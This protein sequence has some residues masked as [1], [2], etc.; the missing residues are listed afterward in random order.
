[1]SSF[2]TN[3]P[4]VKPPV[5]SD[6]MTP[7]VQ[8]A[9]AFLSNAR[10]LAKQKG[11][12][13]DSAE[14]MRLAGKVPALIQQCLAR[15]APDEQPVFYGCAMDSIELYTKRHGV[16]P[17]PDIVGN[18]LV[19]GLNTAEMFGQLFESKGDKS[20]GVALDS[21]HYASSTTHAEHGLT[22][23]VIITA[24]MSAAI[25]DAMPWITY[26]P[27]NRHTIETK[28]PQMRIGSNFGAYREGEELSAGN[29]GKPYMLSSRS[30]KASSVG[31]IAY[32]LIA[33]VLVNQDDV[34]LP[35]GST[36]L[37]ILAGRTEVTVNGELVAVDTYADGD[38]K[39]ETTTLTKV[40][41]SGYGFVTGT[42]NTKTGEIEF[43]FA[44][45]LAVDDVVKVHVHVDYDVSET[46]LPRLGFTMAPGIR[47]SA[48]ESRGVFVTANNSVRQ[49]KAETGLNPGVSFIMDMNRQSNRE[50]LQYVFRRLVDLGLA[51]GRVDEV[52]IEWDTMGLQKSRAQ[53]FADQL[54][55]AINQAAARIFRRSNGQLRLSQIFVPESLAAYLGVLVPGASFATGLNI[56]RVGDLTANNGAIIS[57]YAV[58]DEELNVATDGSDADI[59]CVGGPV[60]GA[61]ITQTPIIWGDFIAATFDPTVFTEKE[62]IIP[63]Y[64]HGF[65][66]VSRNRRISA[67]V[68]GLRL[69]GVGITKMN[70][71]D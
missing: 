53:V 65:N 64:A 19:A 61:E 13:L 56:Y 7:F 62:Q 8:E 55:P 71:A 25:E 34:Q 40:T 46:N 29:A 43:N 67:G 69:K 14:G 58:R 68:V 50:R 42:I 30:Y 32:E 70:N 22:Q 9:H 44:A 5:A 54:A 52:Q 12:A 66:Q 57:V 31:R 45:A 27:A 41:G 38:T 26:I 59:L 39:P 63:F 2:S 1:M 17:R 11:V 37:S 48:S 47:V 10:H 6:T 51:K 36:G 18:A 49:I 16:E 28:V 15:M 4:L 24:V 20:R 35:S 21:G 60:N 3:S 23:G 33:T